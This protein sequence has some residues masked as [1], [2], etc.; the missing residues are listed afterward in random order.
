VNEADSGVASAFVN[1]TQEV[2]GSVGTALLNTVAASTA[3]TYI[4]KHGAHS[5]HAAAVYGYTAAFAVGAA[6]IGLAAILVIIL[7]NA[8]PDD[9]DIL[10]TERTPR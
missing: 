9:S 7:V 4:I 5:A 1:T 3:A 2:G 10:A 6:F 8:R